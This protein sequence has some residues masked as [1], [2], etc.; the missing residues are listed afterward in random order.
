MSEK[1]REFKV[2]DVVRFWSGSEGGYVSCPIEALLG[3][4][5]VRVTV[6]RKSAITGKPLKPKT[7]RPYLS[8]CELVKAAKR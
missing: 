1:K 2:G 7:C 3:R 6:Q 8:R 4:G 5:L